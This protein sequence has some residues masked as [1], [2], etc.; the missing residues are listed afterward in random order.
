MKKLVYLSSFMG[1]FLLVASLAFAHGGNYTGPGGTGSGGG[2]SPSG[3]GTPGP[4]PGPGGGGTTGGGSNGGGATGP[5][6]GLPGG[7]TGPGGGGGGGNAGGPGGGLGGGGG[8][9]PGARKAASDANVTWAAWWFFNDDRFLNLKAKVRADEAQT[10]NADLFLGEDTSDAGSNRM[11]AKKIREG[12]L[13][14]LRLA[15]KDSFYD[16]RAAAVIALGKCGMGDDLAEIKSVLNDR[17]KRVR[18]SAA[19]AMGILGDKEAIPTLIEIMN[20]TKSA[21]KLLRKGG[22]ILPRTRSFAAI[23]IGLIGRRTDISDTEGTR[24]LIKLMND[25]RATKAQVDLAV[26]PIAALGIM[27]SKEAI[28]E[29]VKYLKNSNNR[30]VARSF[31]ATSLG[32]IGDRSALEPLLKCLKDKQNAIV[33]S[34]TMA[35]GQ[36]LE[37]SDT[38][39]VKR[40]KKLVSTSADLS[41]KN[42]AI[43]SLAQIGGDENRQFITRLVTKGKA[44]QKPFASLAVGVFYYNNPDFLHRESAAKIIHKEFKSTKNPSDLGAH[45]I[46][47]GLMKYDAAGADILK[48]LNKGGQASLRQHLAIS[49]GLMDYR[50][51]IKDIREIVKEK[52]DVDLRRNSAI[53]LGLL[54]DR[55]AMK[56]LSEEIAKSSNTQPVLG[57]VTRGLGFIGDASAVPLLTKMVK[58]SKKFKDNTRAFSAVALGLLGDKDPLPFTAS[59][60]ENNNYIQ[61]TDAIREVL[62][63]L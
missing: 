50:D 38:K 4:G 9:T 61:R 59:I 8:S 19:L 46:A 29:L 13:P 36:I 7:P 44:L 18:E 56:F 42:F 12:V 5:G 30:T 48:I 60:S 55:G 26:G 3:G 57:A 58:D 37:P 6:G 11:P 33:Q 24:A 25:K 39:E 2:F 41:V 32:K 22:E 52:G 40:V 16:T 21:R 53:A 14:V 15:L 17:D 20:N 35:L 43:M 28:P 31:A 54:G 63:I 47:L 34:S 10:E 1:T 45:A 27:K 49:L 62:T 23:A 51:S